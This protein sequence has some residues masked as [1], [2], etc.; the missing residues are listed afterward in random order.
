MLLLIK[1]RKNTPRQIYQKTEFEIKEWV[2]GLF[3]CHIC[4]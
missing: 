1:I 3:H 4:F 2:S